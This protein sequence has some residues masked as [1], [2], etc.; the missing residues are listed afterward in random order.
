MFENILIK[1]FLCMCA[2]KF[3]V[4]LPSYVTI[5]TILFRTFPL[6]H[7]DLCAIYSEFLSLPHSPGNH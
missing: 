6:P 1:P 4:Y 7:Q 5:I 2:R 3:L